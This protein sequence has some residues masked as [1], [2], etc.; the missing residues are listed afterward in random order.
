MKNG[1]RNNTNINNK[2]R[3]LASHEKQMTQERTVVL[4]CLGDLCN[5]L[6]GNYQQMDRGLRVDVPDE[7]G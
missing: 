6:S 4:L 5:F 1:C 2:R 7:Q 3:Y